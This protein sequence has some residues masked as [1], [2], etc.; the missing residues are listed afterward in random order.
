MI[1]WLTVEL[2]PH[3]YEQIS[4]GQV[5]K[6]DFTFPHPWYISKGANKCMIQIWAIMLCASILKHEKEK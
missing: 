3:P 2:V 4:T 6:Q 5:Y 1:I